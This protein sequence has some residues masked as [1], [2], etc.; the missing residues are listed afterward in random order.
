MINKTIDVE[1][2]LYVSNYSIKKK[3]PKILNELKILSFDTE[4]RSVYE[5]TLRKEAS[6][7]IKETTPADSLYQ[8]AM[9]VANSSGL[10]YPSIV[11][12]THF[13]FGESRSKSHIVVCNTPEMELFVWNLVAEYDGLLLV[14]NSLF[15]LKIMYQ[16][17]GKMPKNFKDTALMV[18]CLINH[19]NIWKAK[20]GLKELMGAYYTPKWTLM[21]DY[22]PEDLKDEDFLMYAAVDGAATFYLYELILDWL[23]S[24]NE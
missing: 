11:N 9:V 23:E 3:L 12:T 10:S 21:N 14:H 13:I 16:R 6:D 5:E 8:Q 2:E 19:V 1:Y 22:E 24:D 17:I 4:V 7:Y 20:T 15:D 18:K